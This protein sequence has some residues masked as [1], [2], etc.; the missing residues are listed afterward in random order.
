MNL[1]PKNTSDA[2]DGVTP[3]G[4]QLHVDTLPVAPPGAAA[5]G[6]PG[7]SGF[8]LLEELGRGGMGVV[9]KA[10]QIALNRDVALKMVLAGAHA[11]QAAL[12]RFHAEALAVAKLQHPHIV[13]IFVVGE[14]DDRPYIALE[15]VAGGNLA[16]KL[17]GKPQPPR[18]AAAMALTLAE[19][20]HFAHE[21]GIV[22]RDL[23]P[24]NVLLTSA[25]TLKITDFGLAKQLES[26]GGRT[27]TGD[28]LGTPTYMAPEQASGVT[29][30]IGP[31]CDVYAL[32]VIL[33]EMLSGRA[34]FDRL[35]PLETLL[36]VVSE[37]PVPLRRLQPGVPRDL[38][39]I[40]MKCLEKSPRKRYPS[41]R[42]LAADLRRFL[43]S[44]PIA[45]RPTRSWE[46]AMKW[47]RRRPARAVAV[48]AGLLG[49][50]LLLAGF[51]WHYRTLAVE[52]KHTEK[53]RL[54][55]DE[56]RRRANANLAL[57][58]EIVNGLIARGSGEGGA[59]L[60]KNDPQRAALLT[61]ALDF[62][63][64]LLKQNPDS[65]E[66]RERMG[67][68]H[69]QTADIY[70]IFGRFD[71]A[72]AEYRQAIGMLT[73]LDAPS[74]FDQRSRRDLA[75]AYNNFGN[76]L[77]ATGRLP[78]AEESYRQ[79]QRCFRALVADFPDE[80]DYQQLLAIT[81]NNISLVL[82]A[83]GHSEESEK[84]LR[85]A[86][87]RYEALAK[88]WPDS[89]E[90]RE[91]LAGS[92]NNL[93]VLY[94][95]S[96]D[97][98][99]AEEAYRD[100]IKVFLELH[101]SDPSQPNY[102]NHLARAH[103]NLAGALKSQ[104]KL[105][106]AAR[107]Y[108]R[109]IELLSSLMAEFGNLPEYRQSLGATLNNLAV[110]QSR[111]GQVPEALAT[112]ERA[113]RLFEQEPLETAGV[114]QREGLAVSLNALA[115]H[116][117]MAGDLPKANELLEPA[118]RIRRE[119]AQR[120]P[121][122]VYTKS[123]LGVTLQIAADLAGRQ[124]DLA[125]ARDL[126]QEAVDVERAVVDAR[127]QV[128]NYRLLLRFNYAGL[129]DTL[130]QLGDPSAAAQVVERLVE[131]EPAA[132]VTRLS[133]AELIARILALP[134]AKNVPFDRA[135]VSALAI[136]QLR[137]AMAHEGVTPAQ[138]EQSEALVPLKSLADFQELLGKKGP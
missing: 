31:T 5:S 112:Y 8:V 98:P 54:R 111:F 19:A 99:R 16:K 2:A 63:R 69:S 7:V 82:S 74:A 97:G 133:V 29:T 126:W 52:L 85:Q 96:G 123:A 51:A 103:N 18:E 107:E 102:R 81:Y 46:R 109:A 21:Q 32:G 95:R 26:G 86:I 67:L 93:A 84:S 15:Y 36:A 64:G 27:R 87:E 129:A 24:A 128:E 47:A 41:A 66:V 117:S 60:A 25:G 94:D 33:Y 53:E 91:A 116:A 1:T 72:E 134:V 45:A 13:Q 44:E 49:A 106:D 68:A 92:H 62:C 10:R 137:G 61:L 78:E 83:T 22:H 30:Q 35:D 56:Q 50:V 12:D 37:E 43:S 28:I 132:G 14:A 80:P 105:G 125:K 108:G 88:R 9:Y 6:R 136:D 90:Y 76:L 120:Q 4:D 77:R 57:S 113:R 127:P 122:D 3:S 20:V 100:V 73:Q 71:D 121:D 101:T 115:M 34:P 75:G 42:E 48:A 118:L 58:Q 110:V 138:L 89:S 11:G 124:N 114:E 104:Q 70:R 38:E 39:T 130:V 119:L 131:V 135:R 40:A 23:K 79:A 65:P 55:A 17:G 59:P